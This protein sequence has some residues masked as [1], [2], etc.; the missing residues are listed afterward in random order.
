MFFCKCTQKRLQINSL[1][2]D[3]SA[4]S[5]SFLF[6]LQSTLAPCSIQHENYDM[7]V[8]FALL[9]CSIHSCNLWNECCSYLFFLFIS[10]FPQQGKIYLKFKTLLWETLCYPFSKQSS[11]SDDLTLYWVTLAD[12]GQP[13]LF[14]YKNIFQNRI[15]Q[16]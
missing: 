1:N 6:T 5:K 7:S 8:F 13:V 14:A 15:K 10:S 12:L 2:D 4:K 3:C 9:C 11:C 16:L